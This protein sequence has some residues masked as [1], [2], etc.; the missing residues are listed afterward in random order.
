MFSRTVSPRNE[1]L[2]WKVRAIPARARRCGLQPVTSRS[3]SS[4]FPEVGV[5]NPVRTLTS[6][7]LPAPFGP[8]RPTTSCRLNV[9]ETPSSACT[10][11]NDR[12]TEEARSVLPGL[13]VAAAVSAS[14]KT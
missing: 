10:P 8:I 14:A 9:S 11:V 6:V 2:C 5:S 4:T 13:L 3:P 7:D 1:R 12:E